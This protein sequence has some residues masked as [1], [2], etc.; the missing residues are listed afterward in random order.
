MKKS[1]LLAVLLSIAPAVFAA[2]HKTAES[3][4]VNE[5]LSNPELD[6]K[7]FS[8]KLEAYDLGALWTEK[9]EAILG[10]IGTNYQRLQ[11]RFTSIIKD[12][13][14]PRRYNVKGKSKVKANVCDFTGTITL[15]TARA[16]SP[17]A[18]KSFLVDFP[19][20]PKDIATRG[21]LCAKVVLDEDPQQKFPGRFEGRLIS[22]FWIDKGNRIHRDGLTDKTEF[23][24]NEFVGTWTSQDKKNVK[25]VRW[26]E[27]RVP[28]SGD[29]DNGSSEFYPNQKYIKNGWEGWADP[30]GYQLGDPNWW[31]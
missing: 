11:I 29:L 21:L 4:W 15:E 31:K 25:Q 10:A 30:A 14:H 6:A 5:Y 26:G 1:A 16:Y 20:V 17:A 27:H 7:E 12:P 19:Y 8:E 24:N 9:Q 18:L 23:R 13:A 22:H 28:L 3:N 2:D